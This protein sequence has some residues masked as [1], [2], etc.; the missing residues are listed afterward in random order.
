MARGNNPLADGAIRRRRRNAQRI[1]RDGKRGHRRGERHIEKWGDGALLRL[2][3]KDQTS[4]VAHHQKEAVGAPFHLRQGIGADR[5]SIEVDQRRAAQIKKTIGPRHRSGVSGAAKNSRP[6]GG[7]RV[8]NHATGQRLHRGARY[9]ELVYLFG[10][11]GNEHFGTTRNQHDRANRISGIGSVR[12]N[13]NLARSVMDLPKGD[14]QLIDQSAAVHIANIHDAIGMT[15][16]D[17]IARQGKGRDRRVCVQGQNTTG[18][19]GGAKVPNRNIA[20]VVP[21]D[22]CVGVRRGKFH[23]SGLSQGANIQGGNSNEGGSH[24]EEATR[25]GNHGDKRL[26]GIEG[27]ARGGANLDF[28]GEVLDKIL[29]NQSALLAHGESDPQQIVGRAKVGAQ[30]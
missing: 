11:A 15:E 23:H 1:R 22:H 30:L 7:N 29:T 28:G 17:I 6:V 21:F 8:G 13:Q 5:D 25:H 27:K 16:Y 14:K 3:D 19:R 18:G 2:N 26:V 12:Q 24:G 9:G 20:K 10:K 4:G